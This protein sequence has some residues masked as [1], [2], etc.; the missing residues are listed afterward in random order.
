VCAGE[1]PVWNEKWGEGRKET[2]ARA[3]SFR[4]CG[5]SGRGRNNNSRGRGGESSSF[6]S[7]RALGVCLS[8]SLPVVA[9]GEP[10][11]ERLASERE[12]WK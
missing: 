12:R 3:F 5:G 9:E 10:S 2:M 11:S 7:E 8:P 4:R 1:Y 6:A